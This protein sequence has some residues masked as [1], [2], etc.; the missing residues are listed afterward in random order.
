M[1]EKNP[2]DNGQKVCTNPL[3]KKLR[4]LDG[5]EVVVTS[6]K[7]SYGINY[8]VKVKFGYQIQDMGFK[9]EELKTFPE[10]SFLFEKLSNNAKPIMG[11]GSTIALQGSAGSASFSDPVT[12]VFVKAWGDCP[13]GCIH[14]EYTTIQATPKNTPSLDFDFKVIPATTPR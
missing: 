9:L 7:S 3:V 10:F 2:H 12:L 8:D 14:H 6:S 13:A 5:R 1:N 11:G 4:K